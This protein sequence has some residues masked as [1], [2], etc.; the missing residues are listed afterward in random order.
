[1][2]L[3]LVVL[4]EGSSKEKAIPITRVPF[5]IG[6]D[7]KCHLRP[8]SPIVSHRHCAIEIRNDQVVLVDFGST[9]GTFVNDQRVDKELELQDHDRLKV[10]PI[11]FEVRFAKTPSVDQRTPLPP[12][13]TTADAPTDD[14]AIA[15]V[16]LSAQDDGTSTAEVPV[17]QAGIPTGSTAVLQIAGAPAEQSETGKKDE[18]KEEKKKLEDTSSAANQ[19]LMKYL[20]RPRK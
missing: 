19:I 1:M 18:S 10:G 12:S 6:R 3:S 20:R 11:L 2:K 15:A 16:L 5:V 7:P 13:K 9:N 4:N 8:G 14:E 17:D